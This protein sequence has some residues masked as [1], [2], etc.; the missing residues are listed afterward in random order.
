[1]SRG[2]HYKSW[3]S[4]NQQ[5]RG[6]LCDSLK[7]RI[8]YFYTS[9]SAVHNAYGRAS[10]RLD[11]RELTQFTWH[12]DYLQEAMLFGADAAQYG[13][14]IEARETALRSIWNTQGLLGQGDFM[15]AVSAFRDLSIADA[16][17]SEDWI[18]RIL[19]VLDRRCGKRT[20][21]RMAESG[22]CDSWPDWARQFADL[23][24]EA[25]GISSRRSAV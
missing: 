13:E 7:H 2:N 16:L 15:N 21:Q 18:V 17:A 25:E 10:I 6:L 24:F 14:S 11:G 12:N 9:Y 22:E 3:P 8:T 19:A 23:R 1:M 4:L 20:L 5:L